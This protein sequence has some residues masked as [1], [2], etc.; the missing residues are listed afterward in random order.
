MMGTKCLSP[1][2]G[3]G[4]PRACGGVEDN[5][6]VACPVCQVDCGGRDVFQEHYGHVWLEVWS[7]SA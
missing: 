4:I 7:K 3:A 6:V 2:V 1:P 5:G